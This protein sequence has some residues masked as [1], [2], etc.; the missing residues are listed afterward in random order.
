MK[1]RL[2]IPQIYLKI[3]LINRYLFIN[4]INN[5]V[6]NEVVYKEAYKFYIEQLKKNV[7]T[8]F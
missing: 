1:C 2:P 8:I 4:F 3:F 6:T 7:Q 5:K